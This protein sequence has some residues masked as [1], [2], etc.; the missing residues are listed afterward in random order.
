[1]KS[2]TRADIQAMQQRY[3][4]MFINSLSGFKSANLVG[5]TD[6]NG[7][8]NLCIVS[9]VFHI[10]ADPALMG[11]ITRPQSVRRD[12]VANIKATGYYT[13]NQVNTDIVVA[14]HQTSARYEADISEFTETGLTAHYEP[15]FVAPFVAESQL[16]IGLKLVETKLL[17]INQTELII[18]EIMLVQSKESALEPDGSI[19][20]EQLNSVAISGLDRYHS[21]QKITRLSY[22]KPHS[23]PEE[24]LFD[25]PDQTSQ[26]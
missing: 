7:N 12:S 19:D 1:M 14:A 23:Q 3:R 17:E 16:R 21:T 13:L 11:M 15:G 10:G 18:G 25:T 5:T 24:L 4:A 20:I 8:E 6:A 9:S 26:E 2:W 22:A